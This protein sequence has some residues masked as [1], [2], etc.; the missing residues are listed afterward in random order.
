MY[1]RHCTRS[2]VC[3]RR[4]L[5][6]RRGLSCWMTAAPRARRLAALVTLFTVGNGRPRPV[7]MPQRATASFLTLTRLHARCCCPR[8]ALAAPGPSPCFLPPRSSACPPTA[9]ASCCFGDCASRCPIHRHVVAV[10]GLW[11]L[12][13]D[14]GRFGGSQGCVPHCGGVGPAWRA[15][16]ASGRQG[17]P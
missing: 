15:S 2:L 16:R 6:R 17:L 5:M 7:W 4:G 13:R 3:D 8:R 11:T 1:L 9:C 10:A 14:F 12:W